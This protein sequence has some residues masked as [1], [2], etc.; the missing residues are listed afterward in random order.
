MRRAQAVTPHTEQLLVVDG[1]HDVT[2]SGIGFAYAAYRQPGT[3]EGYA[4]MQAGLTLT[5]ATG[6]VDH[7]GRFYT[8]PSAAVTVRGGRRHQHRERPVQLLP[9]ER[10]RSSKRAPRTAP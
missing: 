6:P 2:V 10:A 5:G 3:D 7:A 9:A 1:A 8:K 4:G